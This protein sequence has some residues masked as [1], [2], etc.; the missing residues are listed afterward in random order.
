MAKQRNHS[1]FYLTVG[2]FLLAVC[3]ALIALYISSGG[4]P[5]ATVDLGILAIWAIICG[6]AGLGCLIFVLVTDIIYAFKRRNNHREVDNL[7][8]K[9]TA[10][11]LITAVNELTKKLEEKPKK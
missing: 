5:L 1:N 2:F 3:I 6:A 8:D 7:L 4:K 10:N 11:K 9:N